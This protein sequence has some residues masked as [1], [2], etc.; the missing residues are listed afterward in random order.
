MVSTVGCLLGLKEGV[1][2]ASAANGRAVSAEGEF[3]KSLRGFE[4]KESSSSTS[5][6]KGTMLVEEEDTREEAACSREA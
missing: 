4:C 5:R 3:T 1:M 2:F 6:V